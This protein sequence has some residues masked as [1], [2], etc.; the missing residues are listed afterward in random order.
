MNEGVRREDEAD[1]GVMHV[2]EARKQTM[3][4][5]AGKVRKGIHENIALPI[6]REVVAKVIRQKMRMIL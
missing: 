1:I 6:E 3:M 5:T 4:S 2:N